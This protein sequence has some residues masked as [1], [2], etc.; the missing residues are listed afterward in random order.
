MVIVTCLVLEKEGDGVG[1]IANLSC[2][3]KLVAEA[4]GRADEAVTTTGV[5]VE[6]CEVVNKDV[7][8]KLDPFPDVKD[9]VIDGVI[10][11]EGVSRIGAGWSLVT[12][13]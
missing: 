11:G 13:W 1:V 7:S 10:F 6:S 4:V 8:G 9:T 2:I 5:L 12:G 3:I